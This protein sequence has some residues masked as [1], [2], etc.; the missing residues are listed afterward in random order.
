LSYLTSGAADTLGA[1]TTL[2][3]VVAQ[4]QEEN[5]ESVPRLSLRGRQPQQH[6]CKMQIKKRKRQRDASVWPVI[7]HCAFCTFHF[8][9]PMAQRA[10]Q[11][12]P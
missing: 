5:R 6:E 4:F 12:Q 7:L 11:S 1:A 3:Q 9:V 2:A 10:G 8:A